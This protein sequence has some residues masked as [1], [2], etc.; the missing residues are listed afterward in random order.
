MT[1]RCPTTRSPA[2]EPLDDSN[3]FNV[4]VRATDD[5]MY[6]AE[7]PV[8]I[9]VTD[10]NER[11]D[12]TEVMDD[13]LEYT[14]VGFYFTGTP[15]QVVDFAATDY[16]DG[17]TFTWSLG[18][19]DMDHLEIDSSSGVLTFKQDASLNVGPLPSFENPQD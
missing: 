11:P 8:T 16:D 4:T 9:T 15:G 10:V 12:I 2:V 7:Y 19:T 14:E 3:T 5:D 6:A 18:G 13:A 1:A 17:D